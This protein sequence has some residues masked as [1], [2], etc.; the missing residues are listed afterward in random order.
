MPSSNTFDKEFTVVTG[1]S[2]SLSRHFLCKSHVAFT[3]PAGASG[4]LGRAVVE[5]LV[6]KGVN[7]KFLALTHL[8]GNPVPARKHETRPKLTG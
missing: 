1:Q 5:H 4:L 3:E 6:S 8:H 2:L 7:G